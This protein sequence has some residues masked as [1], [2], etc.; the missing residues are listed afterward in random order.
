MS[1]LHVLEAA[2]EAGE[3]GAVAVGGAVEV[4]A[5]RSVGVDRVVVGG[6][7]GEPA[8]LGEGEAGDVAG[9]ADLLVATQ[10]AAELRL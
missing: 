8:R 10:R 1:V 3:V 2:I 4:V 9:A 7:V 5:G 6:A